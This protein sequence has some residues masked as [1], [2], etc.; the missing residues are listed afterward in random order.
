MSSI[1]EGM[2][3]SAVD[4]QKDL[5]FPDLTK[6]CRSVIAEIL[7]N[8]LPGATPSQKDVIQCK[9]GSRDLAAYLVSF[10]C[11]EIKH[12]QGKLVT[13][14]RLDIIKDLQ[15]KDGNDWSGTSM[16]YLDYVTDSRNP[17]YIRMYVGQSLK[18]PRRLFSQHSQ[19]ML[20]GDTSCL[21]YFVVWLGNGRRT[22]SFIR[23]WEFP[24]G[25]GD[26]DTMGDI[27]QRN[28]LE[29]VLCRAFSTHHGSLTIC[30]EESG[31]ASGYGLNVMTPLAQASAVGDYLQAVSKSQM[32]V[33]A[34]PQIR[35]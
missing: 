1:E 6:L 8:R 25:K 33:S 30:D 11:P 22:A 15:V 10:V 24:R 2:P 21:H 34:D 9:L 23:L 18:A 27:I 7:S 19:S 16:G 3:A 26:S 17:G 13:R 35:Y 20:K 32:A 14:E 5:L 28:I 31:L 29:A 12:L 4:L